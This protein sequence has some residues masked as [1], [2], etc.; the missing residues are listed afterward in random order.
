MKRKREGQINNPNS[1]YLQ[2][3]GIV[4]NNKRVGVNLKV[5]GSNPWFQS[6]PLTSYKRVFQF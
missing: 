2:F 3:P 4:S 6:N 1:K 5:T